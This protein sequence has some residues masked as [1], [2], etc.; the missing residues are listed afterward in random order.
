V[1]GGVGGEVG[2]AAL[3]GEGDRGGR[4]AGHWATSSNWATGVGPGSFG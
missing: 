1:D 2:E 3:V 4:A